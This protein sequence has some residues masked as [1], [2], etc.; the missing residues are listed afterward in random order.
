MSRH[1]HGERKGNVIDRNGAVC[2]SLVLSHEFEQNTPW[3]LRQARTRV[4]ARM[5]MQHFKTG[6]LGIGAALAL[7]VTGCATQGDD[8]RTAGRVVDDNAITRDI[9]SSLRSEPVYKFGDVD[10]KTY[11]GVVQ[12]SGF[13]TT[14]EQK[15]RAAQIAQESPGV[16]Q[17]VNALTLKPELS[18]TGRQEPPPVRDITSDVNHSITN[19]VDATS[20][21][22]DR[23]LNDLHDATTPR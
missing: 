4:E 18:P 12:L 14:D 9:A 17:V 1:V 7:V 23:N 21:T 10:V 13:V 11:N 19:S 8:N 3:N 6:L 16:N 5:T 22:L 15:Q 2:Q 20:D